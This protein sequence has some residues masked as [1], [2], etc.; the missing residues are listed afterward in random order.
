[1]LALA[2]AAAVPTEHG[3]LGGR[4][5]YIDSEK[6]FSSNRMVEMATQ[7]YGEVGRLPATLNLKSVMARVLVHQVS[8]TEEI[9]QLLDG[10]EEQMIDDGVVLVC[11]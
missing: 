1:M 7:R 10:A 4:V 2:L 9:A 6:A 11:D 8:S 5:L 3:G